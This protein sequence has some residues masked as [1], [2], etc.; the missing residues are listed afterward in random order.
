MSGTAIVVYGKGGIGKSTVCT[1]LCVAAAQNGLRVLNV[2][3]DPKG[4]SSLRLADGE[5]K[6]TVLDTVRAAGGYGVTIDDIVSRGRLGI[7]FVEAGG[8]EPGRGCGGH[9][10]NTMLEVLRRVRLLEVRTYDLVIYD[11][12]GDV[13]CGGFAAPLRKGVA[14][15]AYIVTSE[16]VMSL[17]AAN[18]IVRALK[19]ASRS[20]VA[21]GGLI[22]NLRDNRFPRERLECFA[23]RIGTRVVTV[24]ERDQLVRRAEFAFRTVVEMYPESSVAQTFVALARTVMTAPPEPPAM[25]PLAPQDF[26]RY[27]QENF[28]ADDFSFEV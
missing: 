17:Y 20:G 5:M 1:S 7:D 14:Q 24:V 13:V 27:I 21:L 8:P 18:N 16:E 23:E 6:P 3:C 2:G 26:V 22:V 15:R 11:V 12:L 10:V 9:G 28:S 19:R 25:T 4:D